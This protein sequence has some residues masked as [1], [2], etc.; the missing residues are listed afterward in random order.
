MGFLN[1]FKKKQRTMLDEIKDAATM[2]FRSSDKDGLSQL[3]DEEISKTSEEVMNSF[4]YVAE[5]RGEVIAGG[6]LLTIAM[7]H[8]SIQN[9]LGKDMYNSHLAYE[10]KKYANEGL[11]E[12]YKQNLLGG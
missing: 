9:N 11:R 2:I 8:L 1:L 3:S 5:Q 6:H 10:L 7:F 12:D 4:K